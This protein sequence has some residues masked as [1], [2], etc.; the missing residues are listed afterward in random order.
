MKENHFKNFR[1]EAL[2]T[3]EKK[4]AIFVKTQVFLPCLTANVC[5]K[6]CVFFKKRAIFSSRVDEALES[7][8]EVKIFFIKLSSYQKYIV[9]MLKHFTIAFHY[10]K[11]Q[12]TYLSSFYITF[13]NYLWKS[14][15]LN[16]FN[17]M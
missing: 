3:R 11:A 10:Y 15:V 5:L 1:N 12:G 4:N 6:N 17:K 7:N 8:S 14:E 16:C 9:S 13:W 2:S